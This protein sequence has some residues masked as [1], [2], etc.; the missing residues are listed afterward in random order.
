MNKK[1]QASIQI[2][3]II[4]KKKKINIFSL[5]LLTSGTSRLDTNTNII[6]STL[7]YDMIANRRTQLSRYKIHNNGLFST[8]DTK[9]ETK[10]I[11]NETDQR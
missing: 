6:N 4:V 3:S 8:G 11:N 9:W 5:S 7:R 10:K 2:H 1:Y